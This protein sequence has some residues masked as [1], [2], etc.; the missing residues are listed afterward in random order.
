MG[1]GRY[2]AQLNNY[3]VKDRMG[4]VWATI[5]D[6]LSLLPDLLLLPRANVYDW[7]SWYGAGRILGLLAHQDAGRWETCHALF[8][9]LT[10][11]TLICWHENEGARAILKDLAKHVSFH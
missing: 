6:H 2:L 11:Q 8:L 4:R 1:K 3:P 10:L 9:K 5:H 7:L